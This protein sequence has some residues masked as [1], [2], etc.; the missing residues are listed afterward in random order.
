VE[1]ITRDEARRV[2]LKYE[3]LGSMASTSLHYGIMFGPYLGGVTC[4][5][6]NGSGTGGPYV[7]AQYGLTKPELAI[8]ARG[9]CVSWAPPGTNSKLVSWTARRVAV[10]YPPTRLIV[11]YADVDAGEIG[12]IYQACN[13]FYVGQSDAAGV[14][15]R[16]P[17]G[18][19]VSF[20]AYSAVAARNN[21]NW[22]TARQRMLS[23]GWTEIRCT[24]KHKYIRPVRSRREDP[25]MWALAEARSLPYPKRAGSIESDASTIPGGTE[26][27]ANPIPA[28]QT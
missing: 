20:R 21:T 26:D 27:G 18:R 6:V 7:Q 9:A 24:P 14:S 25:E 3:W 28:L 17:E 4:V 16:S 12:T 11:A 22:A 13:W 10:D 1:P 2:I 5:G 8:L 15:I 23:E 19:V